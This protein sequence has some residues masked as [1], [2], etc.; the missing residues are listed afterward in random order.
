[1]SNQIGTGPTHIDGRILELVLTDV[2]DIVE[3][4]VSSPV[5]T[6]VQTTIFMDVVLDGGLWCER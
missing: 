5:T 3:V 2:H 1:M 4:R 6:Y